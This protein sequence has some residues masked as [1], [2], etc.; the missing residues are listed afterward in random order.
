MGIEKPSGFEWPKVVFLKVRFEKS[1]DHY[2]YSREVEIRELIIL[3]NTLDDV[4]DRVITS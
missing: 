4:I 1:W 2:K 3:Y